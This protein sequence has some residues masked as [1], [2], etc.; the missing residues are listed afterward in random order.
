MKTKSTAGSNIQNEIRDTL[1]LILIK[2]IV[3]H[4]M[5]LSFF[6]ELD[7]KFDTLLVSAYGAVNRKQ[8][9]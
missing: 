8:L 4:F 3:Q 9:A 5:L 6:I 2:G 7:K 1:L